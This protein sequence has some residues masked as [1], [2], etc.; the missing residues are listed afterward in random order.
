MDLLK[1][2]KIELPAI[3]SCMT[4]YAGV[5]SAPSN[6]CKQLDKAIDINDKDVITY[7]LKELKTWYENHINEILSNS[8][9]F[10]QATHLEYQKKIIDYVNQIEKYEA[11]PNVSIF[12]KKEKKIFLSHC[13]IDKKYGDILE[14][15]LT[16]IGVR[17]DSLIYTSHPMHKIPMNLDIYS[18]LKEN[19]INDTYVI[20]LWS[21]D[22]LINQACLN[23][24]GAAW[25]LQREYTNIYVPNFDFKN[26]CYYKCAVNK[27]KMGAILDGSPNCKISLLEFKQTIEKFL[28]LK[29]I[30]EKQTTFLLDKIIS[31]LQE[32]TQNDTSN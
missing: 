29:K 8:Y 32:A 27:D 15:F 22:F 2:I 16:G 9:C 26:P 4:K 23:E 20:F 10:D 7:C 14:E 13:S 11:N 24:M 3:E 17:G 1:T 5:N 25:V 12:P 18:Y 6:Y 30:D 28:E 19:L 31:E 21:N